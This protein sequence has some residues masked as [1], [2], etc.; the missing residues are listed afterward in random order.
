VGRGVEC[1]EGL[2]GWGM[3]DLQGTN[4]DMISLKKASWSHIRGTHRRKWLVI[5]I[6]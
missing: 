4:D 1:S 5:S 6:I 2:I 3:T